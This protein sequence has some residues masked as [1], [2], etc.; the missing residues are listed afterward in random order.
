MRLRV[1]T[2]NVRYFAHGLGG[3]A[4]TQGG[5]RRI[6][7]AIAH[8]G[9]DVVALQEV[10][11]RSLRG[12]LRRPQLDRLTTALHA[13]GPV[14]WQS[15]HI[16]AHRYALGPVPLATMGLAWLVREGLSVVDHGSEEITHVRLPA[17][18]PIKQ[19]RVAAWIRVQTPT[20]A[21]DLVNTH[22]SLPAFLEVGPHRIPDAM[23]DGSNQAAEVANL[24][25]FVDR[26]AGPH[27]VVVGDFNSRPGS[28]AHQAMLDAG[29]DD[30]WAGRQAVTARFGRKRMHIDHVFGRGVGWSERADDV[31]AFEGLSDHSPKAVTVRPA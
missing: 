5:V 20:A 6:A 8:S 25:A 24:L 17:A 21:V 30:A 2:W 3:A 11:D 15:Q 12:G 27:R 29:L 16:P 4:A 23:G 26:V 13:A 7:A 14:R 9:A 28:A 19:S 1:L 10:E 31:P 22:L 18:E